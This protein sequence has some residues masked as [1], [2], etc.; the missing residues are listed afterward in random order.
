MERG[1]SL[2]SWFE[3]A[4]SQAVDNRALF[5][6]CAPI[7]QQALQALLVLHSNNWY[8]ADVRPMNFVLFEKSVRL[9]DWVTAGKYKDRYNFRQGLLDPFL[10]DPMHE[11]AKIEY[12]RPKWDIISLGFTILG[13][14]GDLEGL[15]T[16]GFVQSRQERLISL[17]KKQDPLTQLGLKIIEV[18]SNMESDIATADDLNSIHFKL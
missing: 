8:H 6:K 4:R 18:S 5:T 3:K 9:I 13:L 11:D 1:H 16:S 14:N 2:V 17:R 7:F 12:Y 10:P 15:R